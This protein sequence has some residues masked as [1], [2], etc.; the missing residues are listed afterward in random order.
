[1]AVHEKQISESMRSFLRR[2]FIT[3]RR[4]GKKI[5]IDDEIDIT[6]ITFRI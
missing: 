2:E 1:M 3:P 6:F 4:E 5:E